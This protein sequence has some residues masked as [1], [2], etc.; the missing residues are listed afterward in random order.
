MDDKYLRNS[1]LLQLKD[2]ATTIFNL[3][4]N[5][6]ENLNKDLEKARKQ[7]LDLT[8]QGEYIIKSMPFYNDQFQGTDRSEDLF[9]VIQIISLLVK[10]H[11]NLWVI[12]RH[13]KEK[14][15]QQHHEK[16]EK[17]Y[18]GQLSFYYHLAYLE[19]VKDNV[20]QIIDVFYKEVQ[21][22]LLE[23]ALGDM[24]LLEFVLRN[25]RLDEYLTYPLS[26]EYKHWFSAYKEMKDLAIDDI[27][28]ASNSL[29]GMLLKYF[30]DERIQNIIYN[31]IFY[32]C[33]LLEFAYQ[34]N[35][36]DKTHQ[37]V[38][39]GYDRYLEID[40]IYLLYKYDKE[41]FNQVFDELKVI[42]LER[43]LSKADEN[44]KDHL[45]VEDLYEEQFLKATASKCEEALS[46]IN[47]ND[48]Q[49]IRNSDKRNTPTRFKK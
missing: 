23:Q 17:Y 36:N 18:K 45:I 22:S 4:S 47:R 34:N 38:E 15:K 41:R 5:G 16:I 30:D 8:V 6:Y 39:L 29:A 31:S 10:A 33:L 21:L 1:I 35:N 25:N 37:V 26:N 3:F 13:N 43:L 40:T 44:G 19:D 49:D 46:K 42:C 20:K 9:Y 24:Y 11:H 12:A 7:F 48:S 2:V 14:E 32:E 28:S 27:N